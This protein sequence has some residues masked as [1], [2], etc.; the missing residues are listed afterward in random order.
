MIDQKIRESRGCFIIDDYTQIK[1]YNESMRLAGR[2]HGVINAYELAT[3]PKQR[4]KAESELCRL[5]ERISGRT[6]VT[7]GIQNGNK[8][9]IAHVRHEGGYRIPELQVIEGISPIQLSRI[10]FDSMFPDKSVSMPSPKTPE[11]QKMYRESISK[12]YESRFGINKDLF[13]KYID[14][15][16]QFEDGRARG[17]RQEKK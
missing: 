13:R 7:Q 8:R 9:Y 11:Q 14:I 6:A 5:V 12:F 4:Y 2:I 3:T 15:A 17:V 10:E 16:S 1:G